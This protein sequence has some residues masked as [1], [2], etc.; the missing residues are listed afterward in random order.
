[1]E[2]LIVPIAAAVTM[3]TLY[4]GNH[5]RVGQAVRQIV[6][7]LHD[8][9]ERQKSDSITFLIVGDDL[10]IEQQVLRKTT[11]SQ[12]QFV[13]LLQR[14]R[15]ERLTLAAGLQE[16]EGHNLL[17]ALAT[18]E[19]LENSP[20]VILGRVRVSVDDDPANQ[21]EQR[22]RRELQP[23]QLDAVR[24]AFRNFRA[25]QKLPLAEMEQLVWGFIDSIARSTQAILPL[26]KLKEHDEY[27]FVHSVN[28]SLLVLAQARSFGIDG[29]ML[30]AFGLAALVH[31]IG[32]LLVPLRV[33]NHPGKL[34]G[35]DWTIMQSHA[36]QGA[37]Y[38]SE[39]DSS[40]P[41]SIL[42]AYEHHLRFD[43]KPSYPILRTSR[44]PSLVSRMTSIADA[45]DAMSTVRPYQQ[46]LMRAAALE[47]LKKKAETF[48]D[49]LLVANFAQI[50]ES[51]AGG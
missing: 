46:P 48:Y 1:M 12:R 16:E 45:Y 36:E 17:T 4:P 5:P 21:A 51:D 14:R 44:Q 29:Q 28:V 33:L 32:K 15:I 20:H 18:G 26:A 41:M 40:P 2:S 8:V 9:L 7:A 27:T 3:R 50:V 13:Q 42:V 22:R 37:W 39:I 34:E 30:H 31:D 35:E 38:L 19:G 10:V 23:D 6:G 25:T 49:P 24:E 47:I 43:E 11:L